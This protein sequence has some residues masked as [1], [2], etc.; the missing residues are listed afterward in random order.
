MRKK[1]TTGIS[2]GFREAGN[3]ESTKSGPLGGT[4]E[5]PS[6]TSVVYSCASFF[7]PVSTRRA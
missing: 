4:P 5:E 7:A 6:A 1:V 3:G 2:S